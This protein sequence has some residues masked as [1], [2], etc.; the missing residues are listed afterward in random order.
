MPESTLIKVTVDH[1]AKA[2]I[3]TPRGYII[4]IDADALCGVVRNYINA[5]EFENATRA[6]A[7]VTGLKA[8][9]ET[10]GQF[11]CDGLE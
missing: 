10:K 5:G 6:L 1:S 7:R 2:H 11:T 3:V 9:I 8:T 4:T